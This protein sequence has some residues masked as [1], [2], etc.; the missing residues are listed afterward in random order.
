MTTLTLVRHAECA[1]G[2][3]YVGRSDPPLSALGRAQAAALGRTLA[4]EPFA[5]VYSSP[6]RRALDTARAIARHHGV[7]VEAMD[8]LAEL[9]FGAW[10][11]LTY[12]EIARRDPDRL[13]R[14][15][16]GPESVAP[17]GGETL[18]ALH[19]RALDAV[20]AIRARHPEDA[21]AV[22]SHGGPLR[23]VVCEALGTGPAGHWRV[24]VDPAGVSALDWRPEGATLARL[25]CTCHLHALQGGTPDPLL[26][27]A[28]RTEDESDG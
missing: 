3:R 11:G 7:A 8:A 4:T 18:A 9:D 14:W 22:V 15:V 10:E 1:L 23:A 25:N 26:A 5:A 2:G 27:E 6:L 28:D 13:A 16:E 24:R 20:A 17:P 21:V 12:D 19:E